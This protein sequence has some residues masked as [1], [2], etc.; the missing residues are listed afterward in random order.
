MPDNAESLQ[1]LLDPEDNERLSFEVVQGE[2]GPA[3]KNVTR[4]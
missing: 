2:K 1:F 4:I 3:A